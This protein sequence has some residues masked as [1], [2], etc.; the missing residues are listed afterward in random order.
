MPSRYCTTRC[1][2]PARIRPREC[3]GGSVP[4]GV[5]Q[6]SLHA[7][8]GSRAGGSARILEDA[9]AV[10]TYR[11]GTSCSGSR[12]GTGLALPYPEA[13]SG[14]DLQV[15]TRAHV[16][17][18]AVDVDSRSDLLLARGAAS[19]AVHTSR[20]RTSVSQGPVSTALLAIDGFLAGNAREVPAPSISARRC[21]DLWLYVCDCTGPATPIRAGSS[22]WQPVPGSVDRRVSPG[23]PSP[24]KLAYYLVRQRGAGQPL[25]FNKWQLASRSRPSRDPEIP[26]SGAD[27]PFRGTPP[28][29]SRPGSTGPT[30]GSLTRSS[31]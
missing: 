1:A 21:H 5:N 8:G 31:G 7:A 11:Y 6:S 20:V 24:N 12:S 3:A 18:K 25:S 19:R 16:L 22:P 30:G 15:M 17:A 9:A 27:L 14:K 29:A 13:C 10:Y 2:V 28:L 23:F 4:T 26:G